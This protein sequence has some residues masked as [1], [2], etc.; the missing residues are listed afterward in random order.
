MTI[1]PAKT[2]RN[3]TSA[4]AAILIGVALLLYVYPLGVAMAV[5][6]APDDPEIVQRGAEVY[7]GHCAAC[8]GVRLEGQPNWQRRGAD[9]RLPAPPHDA[10]GH[11]W[12]HPDALLFKLTKY[13]LAAIAGPSYPSNMPAY[14][15]VLSDADIRAVLSYIKSTWPPEVRSYQDAINAQTRTP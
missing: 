10:S 3:L 8:H 7:V 11:T 5:E 12:H 9:N 1:W 4:A 6:L 13:G 15:E 2:L 14:A